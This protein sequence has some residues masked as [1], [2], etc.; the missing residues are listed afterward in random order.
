MI[1]LGML[2][3]NFMIKIRYSC[4]MERASA[5]SPKPKYQEVDQEIHFNKSLNRFNSETFVKYE[6]GYI[7]IHANHASLVPFVEILLPVT[8][9]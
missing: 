5:Q 8:L 3:D 9:I 2:I 6:A 7:R 4:V 1:K